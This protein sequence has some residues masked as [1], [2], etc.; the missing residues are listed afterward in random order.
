[1]PAT[2]EALSY[3]SLDYLKS[4]NLAA[5]AVSPSGRVYVCRDPK[6]AV[7]AWWCKRDDADQIAHVAW[8]NADVPGAA[9]RLGLSR[10]M[11]S[12][13][14]VSESER[15]RSTRQSARPSTPEC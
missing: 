6:G 8:T 14:D 5:V 12:C 10:R 15:P 4:F 3:A 13:S 1:M 7:A 9:S 2:I 11:T